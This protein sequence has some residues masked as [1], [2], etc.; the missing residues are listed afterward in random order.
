MTSTHKTLE[1]LPKTYSVHKVVNWTVSL[2]LIAFAVWSI[3]I[4]AEARGLLKQATQTFEDMDT[5]IGTLQADL[6]DT[7]AACQAT[8]IV[9][10]TTTTNTKTSQ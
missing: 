4:N 10:P 3:S 7:K 9:I 5:K 2:V 8:T 6:K 1:R